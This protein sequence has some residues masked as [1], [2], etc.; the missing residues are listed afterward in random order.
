M[1][2]WTAVHILLFNYMEACPG[3]FQRRDYTGNHEI[4]IGPSQDTSSLNHLSF[5]CKA[6]NQSFK[7]PVRKIY[8][9]KKDPET[10]LFEMLKHVRVPSCQ[11]SAIITIFVSSLFV[12]GSRE[13]L[14]CKRV[15]GYPLHQR[16]AGILS[17]VRWSTDKRLFYAMD[18]QRTTFNV[19]FI[20]SEQLLTLIISDFLATDN[21]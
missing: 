19:Q 15:R 2:V 12:P 10:S 4:N 9:K 20:V 21:F 17:I 8:K 6:D 13:V 11:F 1:V 3:L 7:N 16:W 18:H 14:Y 5:R